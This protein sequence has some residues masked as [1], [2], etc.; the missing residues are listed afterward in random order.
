LGCLAK[1]LLDEEGCAPRIGELLLFSIFGR[2]FVSSE[3]AF[4]GAD[5]LRAIIRQLFQ[6]GSSFLQA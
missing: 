3:C 1:E 6:C 5:V 4:F 2:L